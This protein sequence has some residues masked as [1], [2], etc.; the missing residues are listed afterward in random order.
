VNH[1]VKWFAASE[2]ELE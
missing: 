2:R 1:L